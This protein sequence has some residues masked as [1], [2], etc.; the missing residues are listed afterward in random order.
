MAES[1][2]LLPDKPVDIHPVRFEEIDADMIRSA[3]ARTKGGLGPSGLDG[4]G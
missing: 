4:E 3:A 1:E 2:V